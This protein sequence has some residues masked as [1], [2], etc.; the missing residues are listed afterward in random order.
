[1]SLKGKLWILPLLVL[2]GFSGT[3][4]LNYNLAE[5]NN[6][7]IENLKSLSYPTLEIT[8]VNI[9]NI[10][11]I[12]NIL[13]NAVSSG[14][15]PLIDE[16]KEI[17]KDVRMKFEKAKVINKENKLIIEKIEKLENTFNGYYENANY[18]TEQLVSG[19]GDFN[20]LSNQVNQMKVDY[21]KLDNE[22]KNF[23]ENVYLDFNNNIDNIISS[24]KELNT[25][26]FIVLLV[27]VLVSVVLSFVI[28]NKII[29]NIKNVS[30]SLKEMSS[31]NADL[32]KRLKINSNDEIGD[33][34]INFNLFVE[35]LQNTFK[36]VTEVINPLIDSSNNLTLISNDVD[37]N[38]DVQKISINLISNNI[39]DL[40]SNI[41]NVN[42]QAKVASLSANEANIKADDISKHMVSLSSSMKELGLEVQNAGNTILELDKQTIQVSTVLDVIKGIAQQTNLLALN[43]A[44]EAARAGEQGR[45]FAVVADE[46]RTLAMKTQ[47]STE[48]IQKIIEK[49][50]DTSKKV[51]SV[52][53]ENAKKAEL[54]IDKTAEVNTNV[55]L[56][57]ENIKNITGINNGISQLVDSQL[58][59][60]DDV[61]KN[62]DQILNQSKML[63]ESVN[64]NLEVVK[65]LSL[66]GKNLNKSC[67]E[68]KV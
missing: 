27:S 20:S 30:G 47:N 64:K 12:P 33:I 39:K 5:K 7:K 68:F 43:A 24:N 37:K 53:N 15:L 19:K 52:I 58:I 22:I 1:M 50:Q 41:N 66:L 36:N 51:V 55:E 14:E 3:F 9:N 6:Q 31:G 10:E 67:E 26:T 45:G 17:A 61:S 38:S 8:D 62:I 54:S 35:K 57:V 49:L 40:M 34:L 59:S 11:K 23:R 48:E 44:I 60:V 63:D 16:T 18:V 56:I 25:M 32:T 13:N 42:E 2:A 29:S 21:E 28:I 4:I 46:V 65:N